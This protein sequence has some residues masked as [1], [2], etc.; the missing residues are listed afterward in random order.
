MHHFSSPKWLIAEGGWESEATIKA[1]A[2][3]CAYVTEKLGDRMHYI[4]TIN[5]A[6]MG[7]Q[8]V[9]IARRYM[10]MMQK[11]AEE[12]NLQVGINMENPFMEQMKKQAEENVKVFRTP[13]P[14]IF[15]GQRSTEGDILIMRSSGCES[16]DQG[17]EPGPGSGDHPFSP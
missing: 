2:D 1:F 16:C 12:T 11:E 8:M 6:N 9:A 5:E 17:G 15:L 14:E 4:C 10:Q 7:L 13:K 3:Y